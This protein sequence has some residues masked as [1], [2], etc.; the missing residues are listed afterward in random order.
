[1]N[2]YKSKLKKIAMQP[3]W[4]RNLFTLGVNVLRLVGHVFDFYLYLNFY[5]PRRPFAL[6]RH[7]RGHYLGYPRQHPHRAAFI[8]LTAILVAGTA[9]M[10]H[11]IYWAIAWGAVL[12]LWVIAQSAH[13]I[14][15]RIRVQAQRY[16]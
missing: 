3:R 15:K 13:I 10:P 6:R 14:A 4:K 11:A 9:I 7:P 2:D 8:I 5:F 16:R 1:M 12:S